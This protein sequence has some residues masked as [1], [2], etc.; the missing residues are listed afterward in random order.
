VA[1]LSPNLVTPSPH[2]V[3]QVGWGGYK[4]CWLFIF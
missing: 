1:T 3:S 4:L 2:L